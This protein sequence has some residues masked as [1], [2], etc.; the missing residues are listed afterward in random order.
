MKSYAA[1]KLGKH[2]TN[3]VCMDQS[4]C[5][6]LFPDSELQ[7]FLTAKL[8]SLY[9]RVKQRKDIEDACIEGLEECPFCEYKMVIDNEQERLFT[10]ENEDCG[11]VSCRQCR[12]LDHLPKTCKGER[13]KFVS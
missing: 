4:G 11:A 12:K 1:E 5:K 7:R 6:L 8:L 10:C 13:T 3:I 2:D 9:E